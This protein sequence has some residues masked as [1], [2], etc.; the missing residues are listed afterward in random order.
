MD[1]TTSPAMPMVSSS[2]VEIKQVTVDSDEGI[3]PVNE[4]LA[5]GWRLLHIGSSGSK[6]VYVL[7]KP[8]ESSRRRTG[9]IA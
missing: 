2:I 9:F 3:S 8:S 5:E 6:T 7:G 1:S 4:L